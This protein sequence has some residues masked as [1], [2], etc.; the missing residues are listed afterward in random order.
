MHLRN[1]INNDYDCKTKLLNKRSLLKYLKTKSRNLKNCKMKTKLREH[2][3]LLQK[4]KNFFTTNDFLE[5]SNK[6]P[7]RGPFDFKKMWEMI[8]KESGLFT[9][10]PPSDF[11]VICQKEKIDA[12]LHLAIIEFFYKERDI[13]QTCFTNPKC[14]FGLCESNLFLKVDKEL[15]IKIIKFVKLKM[16]NRDFWLSNHAILSFRRLLKQ[17]ILTFEDIL[18]YFTTKGLSKKAYPCESDLAREAVNTL[19]REE[20]IDLLKKS[21]NYWMWYYIAMSESVTKKEVFEIAN[22]VNFIVPDSF[23]FGRQNTSK[24]HC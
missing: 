8:L 18:F 9:D 10:F 15:Q 4:I 1:T 12:N 2:I 22:E 21:K 7:I 3:I 24:D 23:Y 20:K 6:A 14:V 11:L 16:L 17:G 19:T 5:D 13:V